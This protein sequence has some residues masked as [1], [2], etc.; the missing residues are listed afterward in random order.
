[1]MT[2]NQTITV[3]DVTYNISEL[4]SEAKSLIQSYQFAESEIQRANAMVAVLTTAK[5]GYLAD[6]K[7]KLPA[8]PQTASKN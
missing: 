3:D 4:S 8:V 6:L 2:D 1:M 7:T 5:A